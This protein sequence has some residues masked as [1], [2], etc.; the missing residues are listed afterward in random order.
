MSWSDAIWVFLAISLLQPLLLQRYLDTRRR[1]LI[2]RLEKR[3]GSRVIL[4]V[5][6]QETMRLLGFPLL[7]YIDVNDSEEVLRAIQLTDPDVPLDLILQTPGGLALAAL[8]I[9]RALKARNA[10]VTV[11]VPHYAMSGGT[12][13]ALA[14]SGIVLSPHAVL[15]P[16]DPQIG[17]YPAATFLKVVQQKEPADL[18]DET[19]IKADIASKALRQIRDAVAGLLAGRHDEERCFDIATALTEGRWTHDFPIFSEF[20]AELGLNVSTAM[21]AEILQLML[22]YPQPV[23]GGGGGVEYLPGH[24]H[25]PVARP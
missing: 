21:P 12:L 22:L 16:I 17:E 13:I 14:A 1:F 23:R 8:Q 11:F 7:R 6:R 20:A 15:G 19:L 18:D 4:L 5:H 24:R 25:K 3:R 10:P 2:A 9:A